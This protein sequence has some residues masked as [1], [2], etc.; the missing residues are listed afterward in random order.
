MAEWVYLSGKMLLSS[1]ASMSQAFNAFHATSLT[2]QKMQRY[3]GPP[4][5]IRTGERDTISNKLQATQLGAVV[6]RLKSC[7]KAVVHLG[8]GPWD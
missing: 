7:L 2:L 8:I 1:A 3:Q 5:L 6:G 4:T